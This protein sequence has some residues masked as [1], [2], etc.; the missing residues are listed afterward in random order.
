MIKTKI[1]S[2]FIVSLASFIAFSVFLI[3]IHSKDLVKY[4]GDASFAKVTTYNDLS[5]KAVK[6]LHDHVD[7]QILK[8]FSKV[9]NDGSII[10]S[11]SRD[12]FDA[13]YEEDPGLWGRFHEQLMLW[14][15]FVSLPFSQFVSSLVFNNV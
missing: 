5:D 10:A 11:R 15:V 3:S 2:Y 8:S 4:S 7:K 12:D 13:T 9:F 1:K 14:R 6:E